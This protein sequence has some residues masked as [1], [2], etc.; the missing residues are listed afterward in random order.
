MAVSSVSMS[1]STGTS[2]EFVD[3]SLYSNL[4]D[5]E[6]LQLAI[7]RSL[8]DA[9]NSGLGTESTN[10]TAA[11][12]RPA[13]SGTVPPSHHAQQQPQPYACPANPPR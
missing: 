7:E 5:D 6:L 1:G 13:S 4:S 10:T 3:Y 11:L 12:T 2:M 9:H 8:A